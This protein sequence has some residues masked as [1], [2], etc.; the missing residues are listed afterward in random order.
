M[1]KFHLEH[2]SIENKL[3]NQSKFQKETAHEAV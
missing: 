1:L 3:C 2:D